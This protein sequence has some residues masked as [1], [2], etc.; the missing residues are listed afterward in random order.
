MSMSISTTALKEELDTTI[1]L[2]SRFGPNHAGMSISPVRNPLTRDYPSC[3]RNVDSSG[4]II[5]GKDDDPLDYFVRTSDRFFIK[6]GEEFDLNNPIKLKQWE[7]IKFSDLI[8]DS[9][10]K[11]DENGKIIVEPSDKASSQAVYYVE[12]IIEETKKR[13]TASRKLNKALNY[14][15]NAS[16]DSLR[17][18]AMLLGKYIKD[19]YDEEIEEFLSEFA[20]KDPDKVISL[21]E[22]N[23]TKY[24]IAFTYAKQK[25]I[26]RQ[27]GGL[28]TYSDSDIIGRDA[29]S[30]VEFMKNPKN[31]IITD[32]I[33]K[34]V[35]ELS[36]KD[37]D[38]ITE[39]ISDN[40]KR[41][42]DLKTQAEMHSKN[43]F[44]N[45]SK[46]DSELLSTLEEAE[47]FVPE[48]KSNPA[49]KSSKK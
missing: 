6:D 38:V 40:N 32:R 47:T 43:D 35:Q 39:S 3:V 2:R 12:R 30:C 22:S 16:R 34:D 45:D 49:S 33:L 42:E 4:N 26:I 19:A 36:V 11:T 21:F 46:S 5:L 17:I 10:G 24:L 37:N 9:R 7:A 20:K 44:L 48:N 41:V 23:D 14:I 18:R 13:N 8:Y 29:D 31:K 25:G 1:H 27:K 15:Y 28:Y